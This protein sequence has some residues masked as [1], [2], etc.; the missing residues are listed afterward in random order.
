MNK[1]LT[2]LLLSA[3]L[4]VALYGQQES[5]LTSGDEF[6]VNSW[7]DSTQ[8]APVIARDGAGNYIVVWVST[9]QQ[10]D[11]SEGDIF[12]QQFDAN[13]EA[14]G[15]ETLVNLRTD[16]DQKRAA[17]AMN[18]A[19]DFV[20][21]WASFTSVDSLFDIYARVYQN[22]QPLGDDILVNDVVA[23]SQSNPA[24]AMDN[25]G[26]FVV[27]WDSWSQDGSDR[28]VY[29]RRFDSAGIKLGSE[30]RVNTTVTYSQARPAIEYTPDGEFVVVWES[31]NQDD[32]NPSGYGVFG[33]RF[34]NDGNPVGSEFQVN[35]YVE[36][37]QWF[38]DLATFSDGGFVVVWCSWEQDGWDGGIY[39]QRFDASGNRLGE[40]SRVHV[41]DVRYQWLP[42]V[43]AFP[44][45]RFVVVW[46]SW[47]QDGSRDGVFARLFDEDGEAISF[48]TPVNE[49]N[50][51]FQWEPA[52][53]AIDANTFLTVWASWGQENNDYEI[54]A[55]EIEALSGEGI[56][57]SSAVMPVSGN[58]TSHYRVHVVDSAALMDYTYEIT[59]DTTISS[60]FLANITN[61]AR[62]DTVVAGFP[63]DKGEEVFYLTDAFDGIAV[64]FQPE[65]DLGL[66]HD[67]AFL[68]NQSGT[69]LEF[70]VVD[71]TSFYNVAPVDIALIWGSTD[72]LANGR[73]VTPLD[74]A[75][76]TTG[77]LEVEVPFFAW[78]LTNNQR[79]GLWV[80]EPTANRNQQWEAG[81]Q[82]GILTPAPYSQN[83]PDTHAWIVN[84]LPAGSSSLP[85][86]GDTLFVLTVRPLT[87][88]DSIRFQ[89]SR[90]SIT[91]IRSPEN[92]I[93]NTVEL[94]QNYPN[95]FNPSTTIDFRVEGLTG[96]QA[97]SKP[98]LV[99]ITIYDILG[100]KVRTL[101]RERMA[102]G[103]YSVVWDGR[104]NRGEAV[105]SGIYFY[106]LTLGSQF[107]TKKMHVVK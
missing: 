48:E 82:I 68:V 19:G 87:V 81:E 28:G 69:D 4:A 65:F 95:P 99:T 36:N 80:L 24:V 60:T 94:R 3:M 89:A 75:V 46:S 86:I 17:V 74:T 47:Q 101:L 90:S 16:G 66:D 72:T 58:S 11:G 31:W 59:F 57:A 107:R 91:G 93:I 61:V 12:F 73:Y 84:S 38:A 96:S 44:D 97:S 88:A 92:P 40:E 37:Y 106:R 21:V 29:A 49:Y 78:D 55:R 9:A 105:V 54:F 8:R 26:N 77:L 98:G 14:L 102:P 1:L 43:A 27:C 34:D 62:G 53:R 79:T 83:A 2:I 50:D 63:L 10:D 41:T 30:F 20:I 25:T 56:L 104:N 64:E 5:V 39:F 23:H 45:D 18:D 6:R 67:A 13:N 51:D 33:Q 85:G 76:G 52:V 32:S 71:P 103:S 70:E 15:T 22:G 100:R 35:T 42:K 7:T